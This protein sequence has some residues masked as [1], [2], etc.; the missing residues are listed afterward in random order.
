MKPCVTCRYALEYARRM[1][2]TQ[3][4]PQN[5]YDRVDPVEGTSFFTAVNL[6]TC[7]SRRHSTAPNEC[8]MEGKLWAKEDDNFF[9]AFLKRLFGRN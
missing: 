5:Q 7:G 4:V 9:V 3:G 6:V 2:C 1:Y 8:G